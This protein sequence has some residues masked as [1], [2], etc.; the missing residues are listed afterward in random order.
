VKTFK[1]NQLKINSSNPRIIKDEKFNRL[2]KSIQ[3]FPEMMALRPIIYDENN[4]ILGGNMRFKAL[5][6]LKMNDVSSDWVKCVTELSEEQK[7][8]F[9]IK[10]NNSFGEYDFDM[11]ANEWDDLPLQEWGVE[12][13]KDNINPNDFGD[14]FSLPEGDKAPFQQ[15]TFTLAD[16]QAEQVQN[17]IA[18]I[19]QTEE[20]KYTETMGNENSNGNALYLIIMQ[21]AE[22]RK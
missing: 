5:Q 16:K 9:I 3:D 17:A 10:D 20:Y 12:L 13:F 15:M 14:S 19:K 4:I 1:I 7:K 6:H 2:C 18:N 21:W 8:E 11:L 22:Q